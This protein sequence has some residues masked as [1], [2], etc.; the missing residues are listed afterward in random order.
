VRIILSDDQRGTTVQRHAELTLKLFI[1]RQVLP[2]DMSAVRK[3]KLY[4]QNTL[5]EGAEVCDS[6][7]VWDE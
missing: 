7:H 5:V 1:V 6:S 2:Q 4:A 3:L